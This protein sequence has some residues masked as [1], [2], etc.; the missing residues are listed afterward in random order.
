[1]NKEI[2]KIQKTL[3]QLQESLKGTSATKEHIDVCC[4]HLDAVHTHL[5]GVIE[6]IG[7]VGN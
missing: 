2:R 6:V 7:I 5:L 4:K 1:M 3:T